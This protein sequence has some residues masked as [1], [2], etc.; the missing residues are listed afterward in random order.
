MIDTPT[1]GAATAALDAWEAEAAEP[2]TLPSGR[3]VRVV[4]SNITEL[5]VAGL[6]PQPLVDVVLGGDVPVAGPERTRAGFDL[7][8]RTAELAASSVKAIEHEGQWIAVTIDVDRFRRFPMA[9]RVAIVKMAVG[10]ELGGLAYDLRPFRDE[11]AGDATGGDGEDVRPE[12][13][14]DAAGPDAPAGNRAARRARS[15]RGAAPSP[16]KR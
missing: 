2:V 15:G 9:D 3:R 13:V 1:S 6:L 4:Q 11:P 5:I 7:M 8:R 12:A 14:G 10:D 16:R